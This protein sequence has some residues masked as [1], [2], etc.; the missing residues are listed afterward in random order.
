MNSLLYFD[1]PTQQADFLPDQ[2]V[3]YMF[4]SIVYNRQK[5]YNSLII[6]KYETLFRHFVTL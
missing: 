2:A 3:F 5:V 6:D 4:F 1:T